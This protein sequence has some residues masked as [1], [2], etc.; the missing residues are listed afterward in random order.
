MTR[1][2]Y[3]NGFG[4]VPRVCH[5]RYHIRLFRNGRGRFDPEDR[6]HEGVRISGRV[7]T[8][9]AGGLLHFRPIPLEAQILK[10]NAYSSLKAAMKHERGLPARPW[11][12]LVS[13]PLFFLRWYLRYGLWRCGWPGFIQAATGSIYSFLT[14]AKRFERVALTRVAPT[15]PDAR[16]Y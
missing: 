15:E 1:Y 8:A 3:L 5:E 6:V 11:K 13:P 12:M 9:R 16:R 2:P 4:F 7:A 10:E 14:E